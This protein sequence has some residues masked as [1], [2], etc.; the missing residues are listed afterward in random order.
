MKRR[1]FIGLAGGAIVVWPLAVRAQQPERIR[2]V[3]VLMGTSKGD[4][5]GQARVAAF[6]QAL[7]ELKWTESNNLRIDIFWAA[8]RDQYTLLSAWSVDRKAGHPAV[9][10]SFAICAKPGWNACR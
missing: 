3:G 4:P 5:E 7:Q 2:R 10:N 9:A 8:E 1:Q 6:R